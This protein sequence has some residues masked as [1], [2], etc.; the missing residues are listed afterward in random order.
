MNDHV[1]IA[2]LITT[3]AG[4]ST[5]I[6][7]LLSFFTKK[8]NTKFLSFSLG[9]SAGVMI[10][11]SF[12][13]L[14]PNAKTFLVE[15]EVPNYEWIVVLAF[16]CGVLLSLFIDMLVPEAE[17]PHEIKMIES[18]NVDIQ[19][20][21]LKRIGVITAISITIHNFPEGIA[22]FMSAYSDINIGLSVG[23]AVAI[24]NIPEGIAVAIPVFFATAS[25]KKSLLWSILSGFAEPIGAMA[26]YLILLPFISNLVLGVV[27]A[28]VAGIMIFISLDELIPGAQKYGNNHL[29]TYGVLSGMIIM[30]FSLLLLN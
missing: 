11:I 5:G 12:M 28:V 10:Y 27:F 4:L 29:P 9:L 16:F 15:S 22:T 17:N 2:L 14:I 1:F 8:T 30:A 26:A 13:E 18:L 20:F 24:H 23:F 19:N 25:R 7:G 21:K 3:I 6:G